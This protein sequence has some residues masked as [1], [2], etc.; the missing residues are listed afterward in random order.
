MPFLILLFA[1]FIFALSKGMYE[2]SIPVGALLFIS[3]IIEINID[4][5]RNLLNQYF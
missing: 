4:K 5:A 2:E 3:L 1:L